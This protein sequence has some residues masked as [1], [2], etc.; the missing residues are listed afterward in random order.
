MPSR[1]ATPTK[2]HFWALYKQGWSMAEAARETGVSYA[3]AKGEVKKLRNGDAYRALQMVDELPGP[4]GFGDLAPDAYRAL[5]DIGFF[6]ERYFGLILM[7]WQVEATDAMVEL[8]A[9]AEEEYV[10]INVAPGSGKSTF[11]TLVL[12]AWITCR[13]RHIRG[14]IGSSSMSMAKQYVGELRDLLE[15]PLPVHNPPEAIKAG[16]AVQA[17]GSILADFGRFKG[18]RKWASDAFFVEQHGGVSYRAK[19]PS[20]Q[21]FGRGSK[22]LG[23]RVDFCIWDD[24]YDPEEMRTVDAREQLKEWWKSTAETRLEPGGLMV[25]QGQRLDAD[26]IYAFALGQKTHTFD[27]D[28]EIESERQKYHHICFP[29]HDDDGCKGAEFHK[30]SSPPWPDGCLLF[31][32]RLTWQKLTAEREN[33]PNFDVV[34]QQRDTPRGGV[35]VEPLWVTG[36]RDTDGSERP[37]CWD[38]DRGLC[39]LPPN[40]SGPLLSVVSVDPS[41]TKFWA[42]SWWIYHP[43]TDLRFFMDLHRRQMK[44]ADFLDHDPLTNSYTGLAEEW[45]RRSVDLGWRFSHLIFEKNAAQRFFVE[46]TL[47]RNWARARHVSIIGHETTHK[48]KSDPHYG[49]RAMGSLWMHG[50]VRLP[51]RQHDPGRAVA[52][53]LVTEATRFRLDGRHT[54]TDDCVNSEWFFEWNLPH[55]TRLLQPSVT[56]P[57]KVPTWVA[58]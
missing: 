40:I 58:A 15:N 46:S 29:A 9:T 27:D 18:E 14:M 36:G 56:E 37:G 43:P 21:A 47:F 35:L 41:P 23:A 6:A 55:L 57:R 24:V 19:E 5:E 48:N 54:G 34:Y 10:V 42:V 32:R 33:N 28:G 20:W 22:F 30:R 25:L 50:L 2:N 44:I 49:V 39:E 1:I 17:E 38:R 3:W 16:I 8:Q 4:V 26:D 45:H 11:F 31:P 12:P 52:T 13:Q 51:G 7:P 53:K